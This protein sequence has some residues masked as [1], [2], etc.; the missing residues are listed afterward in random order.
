MYY[1]AK[2]KR[3]HRKNS[4]IGLRHAIYES[5]PNECIYCKD[6]RAVGNLICTNCGVLFLENRASY[7]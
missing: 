7:S 5:N 3:R 1:C 6:F 2:C 4:D